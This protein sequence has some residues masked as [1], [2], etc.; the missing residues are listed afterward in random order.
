MRIRK[1]RDE[2]EN[3]TSSVFGVFRDHTVVGGA[4]LF[5][6]SRLETLAIGYWLHASHTGKG[7]A[8]EVARALTSSAFTVP[9]IEAAEITNDKANLASVRIPERLGYTL[10]DEIREIKKHQPNLVSTFNG[11]WTGM[12]GSQRHQTTTSQRNRCPFGP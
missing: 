8:T 10:V 2:W 1:W 11:S 7:Y 4:G 3:G 5:R 6:R 9:G 12:F